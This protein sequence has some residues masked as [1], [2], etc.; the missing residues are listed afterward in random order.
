MPDKSNFQPNATLEVLGDGKFGTRVKQLIPQLRENYE[1]A[2]QQTEVFNPERKLNTAYY[3][4]KHWSFWD[5][6]TCEIK[7]REDTVGEMAPVTL[8]VLAP[9]LDTRVANLVNATPSMEVM[10]TSNENSDLAAA[11]LASQ[12]ATAQW[13]NLDLAD[14]HARGHKVAGMRLN[15]F[16]KTLFDHYAGDI[17]EDGQPEGEIVTELVPP[18]RVYVDPLADRVMPERKMAG[19]ARWLF[20]LSLQDV[21]FVLNHT[22]WKQAREEQTAAGNTVIY[23]GVPDKAEDINGHDS[24]AASTGEQNMDDILGIDQRRAAQG[25]STYAHKDDIAPHGKVVRIVYYYEHKSANYP[26]GRFAAF[27]PD[28]DWHV[29][30]YRNELPYATAEHKTG[31]FPWVMYVDVFEPGKLTGRC[32]MSGARPPQDE[33]N[34]AATSWR[35]T[36]G[37]M[38]PQVLADRNSGITAQKVRGAG[39][40]TVFEYDSAI[41]GNPPTV[42][43]QPAVQ[44]EAQLAMAEIQTLTRLCED[45]MDAHSVAT[46]PRNSATTLGEM[47]IMRLEDETKLKTNDVKRAEQTVYGPQMKLVLRLMQR[48]MPEGRMIAFFGSEGKGAVKRFAGS[49]MHFKDVM[50]V[51]GSSSEANRSLK[52]ALSIRYMELIA[53]TPMSEEEA[54]QFRLDMAQMLDLQMTQSMTTPQLQAKA[55]RDKC[56]RILDGEKNILPGIFDDP[57]IC[58]NEITK[59]GISA[60]VDNLPQPQKNDVLEQLVLLYTAY[61]QAGLSRSPEVDQAGLAAKPEA[62]GEQPAQPPGAEQPVMPPMT[63]LPPDVGG[64]QIPAAPAAAPTALSDAGALSGG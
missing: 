44:Q 8:N 54:K 11:N 55:A 50:I 22:Q 32:R 35:Q 5:A 47:E 34:I 16:C 43:P 12:A 26:Q 21:G 36:R 31:L 39:L 1:I 9:Q 19:D 49:E 41:G 15:C 25:A 57:A 27:L 52:V 20:E 48:F 42:I 56:F 37:A 23:G 59:F 63:G 40:M 38:P 10:A 64:G 60:E 18:E 62:E 4:G 29:L 58:C 24:I 30:E 14:V 17:G 33:L 28:N 6:D 7:S 13:Y 61:K 2:K 45:Q 53:T 51:P 3:R 46:Y